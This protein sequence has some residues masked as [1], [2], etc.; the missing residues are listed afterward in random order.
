M[1]QLNLFKSQLPPTF[2][3]MKRIAHLLNIPAFKKDSGLFSKL[4]TA[5]NRKMVEYETALQG[6][7]FEPYIEPD[8]F[9][10][11]TT[12]ESFLNRG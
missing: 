6:N 12:Y 1:E 3:E 5:T 9:S 2:D 10:F 8:L 4:L 11:F 7:K